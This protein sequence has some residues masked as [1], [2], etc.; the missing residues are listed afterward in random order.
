MPLTLLHARGWSPGDLTEALA[1]EGIR[2]V[3]LQA[4]AL[5]RLGE[6]LAVVL[7]PASRESLANATRHSLHQAGAA[8]ILLGAEGEADAP[9]GDG[10]VAAWIPWPW[11]RRQLL[12]ALR[13]AFRASAAEARLRSLETQVA[14]QEGDLSELTDIGILLATERNTDR[15]L[16]QILYQA[17][18][19]TVSDAGSLYLVEATPR[20]G[21]HL[22]FKLSQND[23]RP[24]LPLLEFTVP[25][26]RTSLAGYAAVERRPLV[27]ED[28]YGL[29]PDLPYRFNQSFDDRSGY[30][31]RSALVVPMENHQG[32]TIGVLQ[33]INRKR[34]SDVRLDSPEVSAR[35]ALPYSQDMVRLVRALAGQAAVALENSQLYASIERLFEGFIRAA[36]TAIEQRDPAT[37]GHSERV[38]RHTIALADVVDRVRQ[39]AYRDLRFSREQIRELRYACL[40]HDFGKVGVR[41]NVLVKETKLYPQDLAGFR[42]RCAFMLRTAQWRLAMERAAHLET[43]GSSGYEAFVREAEARYAAEVERIGKLKTLVEEANLPSVVIGEVSPALDAAAGEA[44]EDLAGAMQPCLDP[45]ELAFLRIGQGT[46]DPGER[47]EIERHVTHTF[48]FLKGIPWTRD[49][50]AVPAIALG[51]HEKLDGSG[52]PHGLAAPEIP[53]QTRMMTIADIFDA[54]TASDRPYK[55]AV[56]VERAF[57]IIDD[58]VGSG[59]LDADLFAMFREAVRDAPVR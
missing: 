35:E 59:R 20:G 6:P 29:A 56:P 19:I 1:A 14:R 26:D 23:S 32:E 16:E 9:A 40:L 18:R 47:R 30:R 53:V 42:Q 46:L 58:E 5:P 43:H 34:H 41:E 15:L 10:D 24:D 21:P 44:Y 2:I 28:V 37:S 33:L 54:L 27:V 48:N 38:A 13:S 25:M 4:D 36:V 49:L 31:T 50:K 57:E 11:P 12:L 52:Y 51:H 8:L 55:P 45:A 22:R 3:P 7:D 39:G 17:R